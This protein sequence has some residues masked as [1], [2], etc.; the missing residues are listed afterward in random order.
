MKY[1]K[2]F[3]KY[4]GGEKCFTF[5]DAQRFL[6]NNGATK[7][8]SKLFIQKMLGD[9]SL[10][11]LGKGV[12]TFAK[13]EAVIGFAFSPFYYGLEYALTIRRLWT[14][15]SVPVIITC[16][17]A[18]PGPRESMGKRIIVRRISKK[19]LFGFSYVQYSGIFVPV[20]DLE[21][22]LVDLVYYRI[23]ING[24][25]AELIKDADMKKLMDYA[26]RAGIQKRMRA[27]VME[28]ASGIA[29]GM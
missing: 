8:Y 21:K 24:E 13:D 19:M 4:F 22:T 15:V 11:R 9:G 23:G 28:R 5:R 25:A 12:Y 17:K 3:A 14:Q 29:N 6:E 2:P 7:A 27:V 16:S 20:S 10:S 18:M 26:K 1:T